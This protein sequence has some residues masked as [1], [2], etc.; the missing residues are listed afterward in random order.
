MC[1]YNMKTTKCK[2]KMLNFH[3]FYTVTFTE[4]LCT[5]YNFKTTFY[6]E[7]RGFWFSVDVDTK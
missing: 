5:L 3:E 2:V 6:R 1:V 7:Y 4:Y